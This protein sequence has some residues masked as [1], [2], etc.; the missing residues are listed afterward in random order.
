MDWRSEKSK[1]CDSPFTLNDIGNRKIVSLMLICKSVILHGV[2]H[3][4]KY[5]LKIPAFSFIFISLQN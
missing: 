5:N 2:V 4:D 1:Y 3:F